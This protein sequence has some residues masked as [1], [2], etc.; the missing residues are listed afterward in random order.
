MHVAVAAAPAA[1]PPSASSSS[2]SSSSSAAAAAAAAATAADAADGNLVAFV[3]AVLPD[4][5]RVFGWN[6]GATPRPN[7]SPALLIVTGSAAR[8]VALLAQLAPLRTRVGKCFAKH[9]SLEEQRAQ[10][11]SSP[12]I[13]VA[14]GTPHRL[15]KLLDEGALSLASCGAVVFDMAAD[16]KGFSVLESFATKEESFALFG[17]HIAERLRPDN[18][19]GA[20]G[21]ASGATGGA[22]GTSV[23]RLAFFV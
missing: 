22:K 1:P 11:Q 21:A 20:A 5:K 12:P 19:A 18:G 4:W 17:R 8:A 7:G 9:L 14:V 16:A 23:A 10:L 15:S 3:R 2:S 6:K 13:T